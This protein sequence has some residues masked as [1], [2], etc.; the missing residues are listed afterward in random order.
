MVASVGTKK[1][2]VVP[3]WILCGP[4]AFLWTPAS[5]GRG[6][7]LVQNPPPP[8]LPY[9]HPDLCLFK[10]ET[11]HGSMRITC[12]NEIKKRIK[13]TFRNVLLIVLCLFI[14]FF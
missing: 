7:F 4:L 11:E 12:G 8:S 6:V 3:V 13:K 5:A 1:G 9:R 14:N 2:D 10:S